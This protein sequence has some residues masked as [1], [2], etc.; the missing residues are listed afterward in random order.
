MQTILIVDDDAKIVKIMAL[1]LEK[2]GF[3]TLAAGD[4]ACAR[5]ILR[6]HACDLLILDI[7]LP[8][9]T[10]LNLLEEIRRMPDC[11]DTAGGSADSV[12]PG[13][14]VWAT[15]PDVPVLMLS[16]LGLTDDI[17]DGLRHG[18][19]DYLVK[20]FEPREL[21]E[22]VRALLRRSRR[23]DATRHRLVG[24]LSLDLEAREA[25]CAGRLIPLTR[26]E[27]DLL[28]YL[29]ASPGRVFSRTQ[30]LD[31][32]WGC[33]FAGNDRAVDLCILRLRGRLAKAGANGVQIATS[34]GSGYRLLS[35]AD[36][37]SPGGEV[38]P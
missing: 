17:V 23:A 3:A 2:A 33:D 5:Q 29:S 30:L 4:G 31:A 19:D 27:Y 1:Y 10:G 14:P 20:P 34:W 7:M 9:T 18:A 38:R 12:P 13:S 28:A 21:V 11:P 8:D 32:V 25:R 22:R 35:G 24:N 36:R 37:A 16:A 15:P 6:S 26:R